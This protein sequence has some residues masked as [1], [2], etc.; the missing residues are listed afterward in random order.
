MNLLSIKLYNN[1]CLL[2]QS[3]DWILGKS[4]YSNFHVEQANAQPWNLTALLHV[5]PTKLP[6]SIKHHILFRDTITAWRDVRKA[7]RLPT[8]HSFYTPL[9]KNPN[10]LPSSLHETFDCWAEK[11]LRTIH[12]LFYESTLKPKTFSELQREF[13]LPNSHAFHYQQATSYWKHT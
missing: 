8:S 6:E 12:Q 1:A 2:R 4:R 3:C 9:L 7:L 5:P 10:F 11:G 13:E